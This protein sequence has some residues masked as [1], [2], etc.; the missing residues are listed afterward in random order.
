MKM[1]KNRKF[2]KFLLSIFLPLIVFLSIGF[3][4]FGAIST[5]LAMPFVTP[6]NAG[7]AFY[8]GNNSTITMTTGTISGFSKTFGGGV[9][10]SD[11]GTFNMSGGAIYGNTATYSGSQIYNSGTFTMTGGTI[12][13]N[14][15]T[16]SEDGIYNGGIAGGEMNLYGGTIYEGIYS[17]YATLS[18][19]MACNI[20]G[21]ITLPNNESITVE[22]YAGTTPSYKIVISSTRETGTIVTLKGS[23]TEP[24]VSKLNISGY[25][26]SK[27]VVKTVKDSSGNWTI[28]LVDNS[29]D[30]P[31]AWKTEVTST[32]YMTTTVTPANLTSIKFVASV[33]SG[34]TKIGTLSTG[35]PVYQG[36][37]ATEIAFVC[38]KI[39]APVDS[40]NLFSS[41]TK[42][43]TIDTSVFDTTKVTNMYYMFSGCSG[44]TSLDVNNFDTTKVVIMENMFASCS[45]L[46]SLNVSNFNTSNVGDISGMFHSCSGLTSLDLSNFDTTKVTDMSSMFLNCSGLTSLDLR[47]F[48]TSNVTSMSWMFYG[49]SGLTS[50]DLSS[51]NMSKVTSSSYD[52]YMFDFRYSNKIATLKTPYNNTRGLQITT[53]STLYNAETGEVVTSVPANT[54]ASL[55]YTNVN[56]RKTLPTTWKTEVA[57]STY[58]TTTITPA[59]LTSIKF[60]ATVPSGYTKIGTLST[61]I[62]VYRGTTA[63]EIAFVFEKIY[64][65]ESCS[66]LFS[67]LTKLTTIDTSVFDTT[68]VTNM[69]TMFYG[70][71]SLTTIN[72]SNF[73]T[74]SVTSMEGMFYNCKNLT[75]VDISNFDTSNVKNM[76]YNC[77]SLTTVNLSNFNTLKVTSML[78]MFYNCTSLTNVDVSNFDTANVTTMS[79]MFYNCTKLTSLDLTNFNTSNVTD[80][81]H[82]FY[83]CSGLTSLDVSN[84]NT[85]KV[86]RMDDMF[87]DCSGLTSLDVN[88][89]DTT[90]VL[91]MEDM[92][93]SCSGLTSLNLSNF[94]TSNVVYMT[95]MFHSCSGLTSLD[96][97]NFN[98]SNVTNMSWMF[99]KCSGLISLDLSSFNMSKVTSYSS[100]FNFG[101]SNKIETFKTPYNNTAELPITTGSTLYNEDTGAVV[102]S[103]PANT[104]KSLTYTN[105][106][107][108]K[109]FPTTWKTEIASSTYMT[110]TVTVSSIQNIVFPTTLNGAY[111]KIGTLSTGIDVY[112]SVYNSGYIAF[113]TGKKIYMPANC[114]QLFYGLNVEKMSFESVDTTKTTNMSQMF[115]NCTSMKILDLS[116]FNMA[117]VSTVTNMLNFGTT[118][119]LGRILTPYGN[120]TAVAITASSTLYD[121][122]TDLSATGVLANSTA[123]KTLAKKVTVTFNPYNGSAVSPS[124]YTKYYGERFGSSYPTTT[125]P[126]YT[127]EGWY[128][129]ISGGSSIDTY[130]L[131]GDT[132]FYAHWASNTGGGSGGGGT[133][134]GGTTPTLPSG[135]ERKHD[136]SQLGE[137]TI[138]EQ[139]IIDALDIFNSFE[140]NTFTA[141]D[142]KIFSVVSPASGSQS[143]SSEYSVEENY[144]SV[145]G[146][147]VVRLSNNGNRYSFL[148]NEFIMGLYNSS[149]NIGFDQWYFFDS[150]F[151]V[152]IA[153]LFPNLEI[154]DLRGL[155]TSLTTFAFRIPDSVRIVIVPEDGCN[156]TLVSNNSIQFLYGDNQSSQSNGYS[157]GYVSGMGSLV[158]SS[159]GVKASNNISNEELNLIS[160]LAFISPLCP[161]Q[162]A[163]YGFTYEYCE[164]ENGIYLCLVETTDSFASRYGTSSGETYLA[165]VSYASAIRIYQ[166]FINGGGFQN[167]P[168]AGTYNIIDFRGVTTI[169]D[170]N[171]PDIATELDLSGYISCQYLILPLDYDSGNVRILIS[172]T[173]LNPDGT[174]HSFLPIGAGESTGGLEISK[175]R[176][177]LSVSAENVDLY[178]DDKKWFD[179]RKNKIQIKTQ[180]DGEE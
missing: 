179:P 114:T 48:N 64:A 68:K 178:I 59:N 129:E 96:L 51:F 62:P 95:G 132:T 73:N 10:V 18:T 177:M 16:A 149:S 9:Y 86:T 156:A 144:G 153:E 31:T 170:A 14:G 90:K 25:N 97:S 26:T 121:T 120:K 168:D 135:F 103:V 122:S 106:P 82:M 126:D 6:D 94:K 12:G 93:H 162:F 169:P 75:N 22:D 145:G 133:G 139:S 1:I 100:M 32:T 99:Y 41:L 128:T 38:E 116:T 33:P 110:S 24:D 15:T 136:T 44:L 40:S 28:S 150:M 112:K 27:Y 7:G 160:G 78:Q 36:T 42:L 79:H 161:E 85:S 101:S 147:E 109:T 134:G 159:L 5:A 148:S 2:S 127:F 65:P 77:T 35:L 83:R 87:Y 11:G 34:Y 146:A 138:D 166:S 119:A 125:R 158:S 157:G 154:L 88:N 163:D 61:G 13:K 84:F 29:Y 111:T 176:T 69:S 70:C 105:V 63:T 4:S 20:Q 67:S 60:V 115:A 45:G 98:T 173:L 17:E 92:F 23:S 46:T 137:G 155:D 164:I 66:G 3:F 21:T 56:P 89:F 113:Y 142:V 167:F 141:E 171:N 72:L 71:T 140:S 55:T 37:T 143:A 19:K 123:S 53:G 47:N 52:S 81:S 117:N 174:T 76:F 131:V 151:F 124:T 175:Q 107:P 102:T 8:I 104:T 30:F 91:V 172:G 74:L 54:S 118:G 130:T 39:Y 58:M 108:F 180:N 49:C 57:S 50:L 43:T 80:M 152:K 165:V